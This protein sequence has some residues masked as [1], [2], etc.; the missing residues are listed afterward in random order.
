[1]ARMRRWRIGGGVLLS[2]VILATSGCYFSVYPETYDASDFK[3]YQFRKESD[4]PCLERPPS[5]L[6][7]V[8]DSTITR[9]ANGDYVV[10]MAVSVPS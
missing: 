9:Q 6:S 10:V 1:M 5:I 3:E 7:W 8:C 2:G 4:P